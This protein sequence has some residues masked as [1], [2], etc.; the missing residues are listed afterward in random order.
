MLRKFTFSIILA[1]LGLGV[2]NTSNAQAFEKGATYLNLNLAGSHLYQIDARGDWSGNH[3]WASSMN[4]GLHVQMEWGIHKYV[5]L[6]FTAG[7]TG[8]RYGWGYGP[9]YGFGYGSGGYGLLS[10]PVGIIANF[11]FYQLIE[12]KTSKDIHGDKLDV[13]AGLNLGSGIGFAPSPGHVNA[14][15]FAGPQVGVRYYVTPTIGLGG[16]VGYGKSF[17]NGGVTFKL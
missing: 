5:G 7:L 1:A 17:I 14:L 8:G 15:F 12:D 2:S 13:Y 9:G 4:G 16:E 3:G 6:G 11:H 10:V